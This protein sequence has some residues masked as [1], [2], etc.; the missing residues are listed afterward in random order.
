MF[1]Q[2]FENLTKIKNTNTIAYSYLIIETKMNQ[3]KNETN[4]KMLSFLSFLFGFLCLVVGI[5]NVITNNQLM[6]YFFIPIGIVLI[7]VSTWRIS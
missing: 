2:K 6:S 4:Y 1:E 3:K 5:D 7:S